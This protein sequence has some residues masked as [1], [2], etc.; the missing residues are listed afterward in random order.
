MEIPSTLIQIGVILAPGIITI[1]IINHMT[2]IGKLEKYEQIFAA[3][4]NSIFIFLFYS[5]IAKIIYLKEPLGIELV[6]NEYIINNIDPL[7]IFI[8]LLLSIML[9]IISGLIVEKDLFLKLTNYIGFTNK[10]SGQIWERSLKDNRGKWVKVYL[11][12]DFYIQGWLKY[13]STGKERNSVLIAD[14]RYYWIDDNHKA[15]C[16]EIQQ[17]DEKS[18]DIDGI[19]I[20]E[21][22][23]RIEIVE[24]EKKPDYDQDD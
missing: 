7:N 23:K 20:C 13:F 12:D 17:K 6:E 14:P 18:K 16:H 10:L 15:I 24:M 19:L 8:I 21:D 9:G 5:V 3:I 2:E 1:K 11:R 4:I 22:I